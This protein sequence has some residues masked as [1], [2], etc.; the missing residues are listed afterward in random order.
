MYKFETSQISPTGLRYIRK[1]S[2]SPF[3]GMGAIGETRSCLQCGQHKPRSRVAIQRF[4]NVVSFFCF[5]CKPLKR[6]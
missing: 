6:Q 3:Q 2:S 5:D 1:E 4:R